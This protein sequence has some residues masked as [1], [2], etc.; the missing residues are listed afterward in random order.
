[1]ELKKSGRLRLG[2]NSAVGLAFDLDNLSI[3]FNPHS[4][5]GPSLPH[6]AARLLEVAYEDREFDSTA[7]RASNHHDQVHTETGTSRSAQEHPSGAPFTN[8]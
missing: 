4:H 8:T 6:A 3:I 7:G 2:G 1:M 5:G